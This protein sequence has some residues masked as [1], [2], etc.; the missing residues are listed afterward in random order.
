[1]G[2]RTLVV[3][4]RVCPLQKLGLNALQEGSYGRIERTGL[5]TVRTPSH[6]EEGGSEASSSLF[7]SF[8]S[9]LQKPNEFLRKMRYRKLQYGGL[10]V[11]SSGEKSGRGFTL[12]NPKK[13][14]VAPALSSP[15]A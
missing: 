15:K 10:G 11:R 4:T 5:Y 8:T 9:F 3:N 6:V 1:M 7:I 2:S 12:H 13:H 14:S